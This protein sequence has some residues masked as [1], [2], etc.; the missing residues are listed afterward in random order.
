MKRPVYF[1]HI[2]IVLIN[3]I[4]FYLGTNLMITSTINFKVLGLDSLLIYLLPYLTVQ[5]FIW[6]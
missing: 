4:H 3:F 1:F 6:T 5:L 2:Y